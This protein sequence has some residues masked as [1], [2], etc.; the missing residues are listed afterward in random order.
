VRGDIIYETYRCIVHGGEAGVVGDGDVGVIAAAACGLGAPLLFTHGFLCV[1]CV[2][3]W[4]WVN[5][6]KILSV[7]ACVC[8]LCVMVFGCFGLCGCV[9]VCV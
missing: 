9:Y 8:V 1:D 6:W 5:K 2:A 7:W 4:V 3:C